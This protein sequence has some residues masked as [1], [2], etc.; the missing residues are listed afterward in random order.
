MSTARR[1]LCSRC[2]GYAP[3]VGHVDAHWVCVIPAGVGESHRLGVRR[4]FKQNATPGESGAQFLMGDGTVRFI[5]ENIDYKTYCL[6]AFIH[7]QQ[8]IGEF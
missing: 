6:L 4:L 3:V 2:R 8:V 1:V 5:S 7:D